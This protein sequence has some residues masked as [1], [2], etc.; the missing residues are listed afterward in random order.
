MKIKEKIIAEIKKVYDPEIPVNIYDLGLIYS[1]CSGS[2]D[3]INNWQNETLPYDTGIFDEGAAEIVDYDA[4]TQKI[5]FVNAD[6]NDIVALSVS[7][8]SSPQLSFEID[9]DMEVFGGTANAV[10]VYDGLVAVAVQGSDSR[11]PAQLPGG[12][13]AWLL[14]SSTSAGEA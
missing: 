13:Q 7:Q 2:C 12:T 9:V 1:S 4:S 5:F 6:A 3:S 10:A 11:I 8:P 14:R